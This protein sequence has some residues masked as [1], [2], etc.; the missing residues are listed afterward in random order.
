MSDQANYPTRRAVVAM[1]PGVLAPGILSGCV[2][3]SQQQ[4]HYTGPAYR[5]VSYQSREKP[6]TIVVDPANHFLYLV[7]DAQ[8]AL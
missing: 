4:A 7:Q 1:I 2:T 3:T 8:Q 5:V 6:G